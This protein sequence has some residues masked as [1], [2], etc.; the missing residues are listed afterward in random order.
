MK[1]T[2]LLSLMVMALLLT[3]GLV[4]AGQPCT[5]FTYQGRLFDGGI[6][7]NGLYDLQFTNYDAASGGT[8][9]AGFNT[10]AVPVSNGLFTVNLDFGAVFDGSMRWLEIAERTNGAG[11]FSTL[12]PRQALTAAPYAIYAASAGTVGGI[13]GLTIQQNAAGAPNVIAGSP[14]NYVAMGVVGATIAGGGL[15]NW[16]G[17]GLLFTNS[18]VGNLGAVGGGAGNSAGGEGTVGGGWRNSASGGDSTV[19]GGGFNIASENHATVAGGAENTASG[20][21]AAVGGGANNVASGLYSTVGGG[22]T[23]SASGFYST[24][25]GGDANSA[26]ADYAT[27]AGGATNSASGDYSAVGGGDENTASGQAAVVAGE[28][29]DGSND[30]GNTASGTAAAIGGGTANLASGNRGTVGGGHNNAATNWYA[31]VPGG[32]WNVAGGQ[33]SF[34]AGRAAKAVDDGSFVWCDDPRNDLYSTGVDTVTMRATGGFTFYSDF[35]GS[36]VFLAAGSGSWTSLSDRDA[37]E[38]FTLVDPGAVLQKVADLPMS[39]WNYKSQA[40]SIRHLGPMAQDFKAAFAIGESDKGITTVDA[41]GVAL[42]AIQ[43]LNQKVEAQNAALRAENAELKA[44]LEKLERL[45]QPTK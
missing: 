32:A 39:T 35:T 6:P 28:G 7:A 30:L 12:A 31:T 24:V 20:G 16:Q 1:T 29:Y 2:K 44:R 4:V 38:N 17:D 13:P 45:L 19:G 22:N 21:C 14:I 33:G 27:V 43:G 23:N 11:S 10:N 37:K 8:A 26:S 34:A 18:V 3:G 40:A 41:D 36:G 5:A 15:T 9:L 25:G 42:A